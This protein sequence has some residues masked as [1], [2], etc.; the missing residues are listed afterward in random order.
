MKTTIDP[1]AKH[2]Q[3]LHKVQTCEEC[4][5][6]KAHGTQIKCL[7]YP[8]MINNIACIDFEGNIKYKLRMKV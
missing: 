7:V 1:W 3:E 8:G 5:T 6:S 2:M 4:E